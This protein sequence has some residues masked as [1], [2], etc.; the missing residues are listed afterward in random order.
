MVGALM[1][2]RQLVTE[3]GTGLAN[4]M[5]LFVSPRDSDGRIPRHVRTARRSEPHRN[6]SVDPGEAGGGRMLA[7]A[8]AS[9]RDVPPSSGSGPKLLEC[10]AFQT[11]EVAFAGGSLLK[12]VLR[13]FQRRDRLVDHEAS[14]RN[15]FVQRLP[16]HGD[17]DASNFYF[18][19]FIVR[20]PNA[21]SA[22]LGILL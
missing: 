19:L 13:H 8:G 17:R 22:H 10:R 11:V 9:A 16:H 15:N 20:S 5:R 1:P 6:R 4:G 21:R 2:D 18:K 12:N 14:I 7:L 3:S